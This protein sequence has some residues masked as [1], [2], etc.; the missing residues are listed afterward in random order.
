MHP[1]HRIALAFLLS[2]TLDDLKIPELPPQGQ[3]Q[4]PQVEAWQECESWADESCSPALLGCY[5]PSSQEVELAGHCTWICEDSGDCAE[6]WVDAMA[7]PI[8]IPYLGMQVGV[9]A[10][11]CVADGEC[12]DG[13]VCHEVE[14][15]PGLTALICTWEIVIQ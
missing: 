7:K 15:T 5:M 1:S 11:S 9:C 10:L 12:P 6:L 3:P 8:C 13:M 2:C 4:P 14:T